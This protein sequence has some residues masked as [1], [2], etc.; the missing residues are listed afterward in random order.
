M[1]EKLSTP[2]SWVVELEYDQ[3]LWFDNPLAT[4][5]PWSPGNRP[6][7][8]DV[9]CVRHVD[10]KRVRHV[11]E[12]EATCTGQGDSWGARNCGQRSH[13]NC[14]RAGLSVSSRAGISDVSNQFAGMRDADNTQSTPHGCT[15]IIILDVKVD[16][17]QTLMAG[18]ATNA[19]ND[20]QPRICLARPG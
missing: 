13:A 17:S 11:R 14:K 10:V 19:K 12:I 2:T 7:H 9:K 16:R 18:I 5:R 6:R 20:S 4:S 8:R 3:S 15:E 1:K